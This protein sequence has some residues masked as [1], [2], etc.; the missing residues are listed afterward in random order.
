MMRNFSVAV[1]AAIALGAL[2]ALGVVAGCDKPSEDSCRKALLNMQHLMGTDSQNDTTF[3]EGEVRRCRGGSRRDAVECAV[4]ATTLDELQ[5]CEFFK[6]DMNK[7]AGSGSSAG[8]G[9]GSGNGS[10]SGSGNGSGSSAH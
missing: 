1:L 6:V 3:L 5:R 10:G 4:K 9:S 7:P 2:G 8:S